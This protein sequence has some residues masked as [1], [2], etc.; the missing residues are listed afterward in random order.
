MK[1]GRYGINV[2]AIAPGWFASRMSSAIVERWGERL[3]GTTPLGR[4]GGDEDLKG[5]IVYLASR[6]SDYVTGQVF[7]VDGGQSA[8]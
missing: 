8:L 4:I 1:W 6:A 3:A 2:N 7:V 5:T